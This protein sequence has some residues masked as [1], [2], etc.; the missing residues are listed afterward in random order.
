MKSFPVRADLH[1]RRMRGRE[2][3][4]A[5]DRLRGRILQLVFLFH[6]HWSAIILL[7]LRVGG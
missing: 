4:P 1:R 2:Q 5:G 6:F 7:G 3:F